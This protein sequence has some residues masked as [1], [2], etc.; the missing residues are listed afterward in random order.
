MICLC[1]KLTAKAGEQMR[2]AEL[3][4]KLQD[5]SRQEP[6]CL[7][8]IVHQHVDDPRKFLVYEQYTGQSALDLHRNSEHFQ[9]LAAGA[10][11]PLIEHREAELYR[12]LA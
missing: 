2:V 7:L 3:F 1:V 4:P 12:P 5:A 11:Y 8:Y 9:K 6:G 10:I